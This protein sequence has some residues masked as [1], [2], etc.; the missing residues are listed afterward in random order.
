M[1]VKHSS[2]CGLAATPVDLPIW[3]ELFFPAEWLGLAI[4]PVYR[5][6]GI[7]KGNREPV[8]LVPGFLASDFSLQEMHLWLE[9]IGYDAHVGG[10]GL[11]IDCPDV[12][13]AKLTEHI[14]EVHRKTRQPVRLIGHSLGGTLARAAASKRPNLVAQVITLG[15]PLHDLRIHPYMMRLARAVEGVRPS[16]DDLPRPH[17]GHFHSG[18]CSHEL[19]HIM[20]QPVPT[21]I[22]HASIYSKHDGVVDWNSSYDKE[23]G[24]VNKEVS[25]THLGLVVN[26]QVYR[27]IAELQATVKTPA[28]A[29][30]GSSAK[31]RA[32]RKAA[33]AAE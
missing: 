23:P 22:P 7:S 9:R 6:S 17:D 12:E 32:K 27:A 29:S 18:D 15:S 10:I 8:I 20:E 14:A 21:G 3:R 25:G 31:Q 13:L 19:S 5:G 24:A 2:Y 30:N 4:S 26:A 16:P 11:D 33:A 1:P 28:P